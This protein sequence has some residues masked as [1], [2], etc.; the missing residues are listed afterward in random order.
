MERK[1]FCG[2]RG[3]DLKQVW[4]QIISGVGHGSELNINEV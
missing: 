4:L 2:H 3:M 1:K